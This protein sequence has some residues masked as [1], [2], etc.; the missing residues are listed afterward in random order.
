[1]T[2]PTPEQHPHGHAH[3]HPHS[4]SHGHGVP[5]GHGAPHA[6]AS[7]RGAVPADSAAVGEVQAAVWQV[8]YDGVVPVTVLDAFRPEAFAASWRAS[9]ET[10]PAG[11]FALLVARAGDQVVGFASVGPTQDPDADDE[12]G[13]LLA[14]AVHPGARRAGHGSRLVN[15][16]V[17]HLMDAGARRV[18]AWLLARDE[19]TRAFLVGAGFAPDGAFRDRVVGPNGETAREVR[20]VTDVSDP[21]PA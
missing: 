6:D 12:T 4:A 10:P 21:A 5:H 7:V 14:L 11:A 17:A 9:L 13:E 8:A 3:P 1:M 2:S 16:A 18:H 20:V 15:A 19:D